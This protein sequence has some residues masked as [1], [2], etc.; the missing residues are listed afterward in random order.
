MKSPGNKTIKTVSF[1][2]SSPWGRRGKN[3]HKAHSLLESN[4]IYRK[5]LKGRIVETFQV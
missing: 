1:F 2:R 3:M 4:P 5:K